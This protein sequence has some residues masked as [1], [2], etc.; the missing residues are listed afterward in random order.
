M[1]IHVMSSEWNNDWDSFVTDHVEGSIFHT[2]RWKRILDKSNLGISSYLIL[3]E[4]GRVVGVCPIYLTTVFPFMRVFFSLPSSD[5]GN[6]LL[7]SFSPC[8]TREALS[9]LF[10]KAACIAN[11]YKV[12]FWKIILPLSSEL[13]R[14]MPNNLTVEKEYGSLILS[15]DEDIESMFTKKIHKKTRTSIRKAIKMGLEAKEELP[16]VND[17]YDLYLS[18]MCRNKGFPEDI[19]QLKVIWNE[20]EFKKDY[21]VLTAKFNGRLVAVILAFLFKNRAYVWKNSSLPTYLWLNPNEFLYWRLI[22]QLINRG[23]KYFQEPLW[24]SNGPIMSILRFLFKSR[25]VTL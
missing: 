18:T 4:T 10:S 20:L 19:A 16:N 17:F 21:T 8:K 1:N 6:P 9:I 23:F 12:S 2:I 13:N 5:Y 15:L 3:E 14:F 22:E 7:D 11:D 25:F 24:G